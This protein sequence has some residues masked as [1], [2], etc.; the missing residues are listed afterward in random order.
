MLCAQQQVSVEPRAVFC[1]AASAEATSTSAT[2]CQ[3][4]TANLGRGCAIVEGWGL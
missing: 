1:C 2:S 4:Y 3:T